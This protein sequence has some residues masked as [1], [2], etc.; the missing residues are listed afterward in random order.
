LA[1]LDFL[2]VLG[3]GFWIFH[4]LPPC[5]LPRVTQLLIGLLGAV[6]AADPPPV[7]ALA[8]APVLAATNRPAGAVAMAEAPAAGSVEKEYQ[9]LLDDDNAAQAEVDKWIEDNQAF[10]AQ[11]AAVPGPQLREKIRTRL[12][13]VRKAYE[14]FLKR[15][16][17]HV[18]ARVAYGS[19]LND[20][21]DEDGAQQQ[22]E[23]ALELE[24]N[25]PAIYNNLAPIYAHTGPVKKAFEFY[26]KA[27]ALKPDEPLYY[28][29]LG[30]VVYLF[31][32]DA[33]EYYGINEQQVFDKALQLYS[34][35]MRL[36]PTNFPLASE[37]AQTYYG[38]RPTRLEDALKAWTNAL[39]LAHDGIE[40]EGV[41]LHFARVK[42]HAGRFAEARGHLNAVTNA[43]YT[44][45]KKRLERSLV[46]L[47]TEAK[48]TNAAPAAKP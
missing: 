22:W 6:L 45:L 13:P 37:V 11:G 7:P 15:H 28:H 12:E 20:L 4:P 48:G 40:R 33:Q 47:E 10:D 27:I 31:R 8:P 5:Y 34:N 41:E 9:Q 35:A 3:V 19:F 25:N 43:M 46:G 23:K 16:P 2:W 14:E 36:D 24:T 26:S 30:N 38:I 42:M 29:N 44:T 1:R 32:T 21:R 39:H 18:N 17:D